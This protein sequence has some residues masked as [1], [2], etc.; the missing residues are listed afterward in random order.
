MAD[1]ALTMRIAALALAGLLFILMAAIW[2]KAKPGEEVG[3][4]FLIFSG[5]AVMLIFFGLDW[6]LGF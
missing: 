5:I 4:P 3:C 6:R 2:I 1:P